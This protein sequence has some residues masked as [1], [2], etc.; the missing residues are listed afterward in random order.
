M[1]V[2]DKLILLKKKF[3]NYKN[4]LKKSKDF[5]TMLDVYQLYIGPQLI[6]H[7]IH[8]EMVRAAKKGKVKCKLLKLKSLIPITDKIK[9]LLINFVTKQIQHLFQSSKFR[10]ISTSDLI[11]YIS[12]DP[13]NEIIHLEEGYY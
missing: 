8:Y 5:Q 10:I 1:N 12:W 7:E 9:D 13:S 4:N 11:F 3:D 2:Y 6:K